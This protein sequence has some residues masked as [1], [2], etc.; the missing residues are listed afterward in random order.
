MTH[1]SPLIL[2]AY[3]PALVRDDNR[4]IAAV[5]ALER[6]LSGL[7][8]EWRVTE[9]RKLAALPQR[10]AW[11]AEATTRGEFP[12]ICNGDER[13]PVM[14]SGQHESAYVSPGGQPQL[15]V[16]A[17][18][19]LDAAV[20]SAAAEMLA[21]LAEGTR[22][23]WGHATPDDAAVDIAYQTAPTQQG[24]PSPR[25]GLP[26]LKLF[27]HIRA[28]EIPYYLGWLNY[29]S[30]AAA[31]AIGFPDSTRDAE[32]LSRARRTAS[33][34]WVVQ[35]TDAPLDLDDPAHLDALKRA[36]ERFPEIGGRAEP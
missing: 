35:L 13:Y 32:L 36:Y 4:T 17:K 34:G 7:R 33:G 10:D 14:I 6:A 31:Q 18:L 23:F 24:P 9:R 20:I 5:H 11:L 15:Q 28:P 16:H 27:E 21:G 8:L 26:S 19:P 30:A 2:N 3:A 25:R 29:W 1:Q 22:A 12:M